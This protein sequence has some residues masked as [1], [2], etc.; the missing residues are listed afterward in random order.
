M[1]SKI[2]LGDK[3]DESHKMGKCYSGY[4]DTGLADWVVSRL[5]RLYLMQYLPL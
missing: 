5:R 1:Y 3:Q 4:I 2:F